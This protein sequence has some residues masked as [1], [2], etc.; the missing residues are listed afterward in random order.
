VDGFDWA[1]TVAT[2]DAATHVLGGDTVRNVS[3]PRGGTVARFRV[4]SDTLAFNLAP[5]AAWADT[6]GGNGG[7][8]PPER[9]RI[10]G[11]EG[12][13]RSAL[14]ISNLSGNRERDSLAVSYWTGTLLLTR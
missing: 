8:A 7:S 12:A 5:L 2:G 3:E 4:G 9:V 11:P 13:R 1:V 6:T 10:A 14:V